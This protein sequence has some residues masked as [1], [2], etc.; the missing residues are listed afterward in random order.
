MPPTTTEP[1]A[2]NKA[3]LPSQRPPERAAGCGAGDGLGALGE[4]TGGD[5]E[6][7]GEGGTGGREDPLSTMTAGSAADWSP[8]VLGSSVLMG[9]SIVILGP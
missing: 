3:R 9:G 4:D 1:T 2:S 5:A 6:G 7:G 8:E